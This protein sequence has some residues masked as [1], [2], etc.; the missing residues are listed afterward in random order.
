[1]AECARV[2]PVCPCPMFGGCQDRR[3]TV[4]IDP[5]LA[6]AEEAVDAAIVGDGGLGPGAS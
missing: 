1:M 5:V 3:H 2:E 4:D 6:G